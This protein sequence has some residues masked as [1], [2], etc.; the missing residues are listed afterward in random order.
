MLSTKL[1]SFLS[2]KA[3]SSIHTSQFVDGERGRNQQQ[4]QLPFRQPN[5]NRY[6]P[7]DINSE[8]RASSTESLT[9]SPARSSVSSPITV[10]SRYSDDL[11]EH[12]QH[13]ENV[14]KIKSK[15]ER[16][17][18][19]YQQIL[20]KRASVRSNGD[21]KKKISNLK[22]PKPILRG[23][24]EIDERDESLSQLFL[25]T[26]STFS[27]R[28]ID[29][30]SSSKPASSMLIVRPN[31]APVNNLFLNYNDNSS[32][33]SKTAKPKPHIR[34]YA[35]EY[36]TLVGTV[37]DL[38]S[39]RENKPLVDNDVILKSGQLRK[40]T[41]MVV[42]IGFETFVELKKGILRYYENVGHGNVTIRT[43]PLQKKTTQCRATKSLQHDPFDGWN[44]VFE[45]IL[46]S[47]GIRLYWM[48]KSELDRD[49]WIQAINNASV[50]ETSDSFPDQF[51][52]RSTSPT[53]NADIV[54]YLH[55]QG[56]IRGA[57]SKEDYLSA[58]SLMNNNILSIPVNWL[59]EYSGATKT[60]PDFEHEDLWR[61]LLERNISINGQLI[62]NA[63]PERA[64]SALTRH[65]LDTDNYS[66][67]LNPSRARIQESQAI[68]YARD[69]LLSCCHE[70]RSDENHSLFCVESLLKSKLVHV[71]PSPS[72]AEPLKIYL[73][74]IDSDN[75]KAGGSTR[76]I[77]TV[78]SSESLFSGQTIASDRRSL[79]L[80]SCADDESV[81]ESVMNSPRLNVEVSVK[82]SNIYRIVDKTHGRKYQEDTWG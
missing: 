72:D 78:G 22:R 23:C 71:S 34:R 69:I 14:N 17:R 66:S 59:K 2:I 81:Q 55:V 1:S 4:S 31:T 11:E 61:Q 29:D 65:I 35:E 27:S 64:I 58:T 9:L 21:Q 56:L 82:V 73:Q 7:G 67:I 52:T 54:L 6:R 26:K 15:R 77:Q 33:V 51:K 76:A 16:A 70:T 20:L 24:S 63:D 48:A 19:K 42:G 5:E 79:D 3:S 80:S 38:V 10:N 47:G 28:E 57:A 18:L 62:Q 49:A 25:Q 39:K 8:C 74:R 41:T 40:V 13:L 36:N 43:I 32:A 50:E 68:L 75:E 12:R 37:V 46:D 53:Y 30:E 45:L 44:R 60:K